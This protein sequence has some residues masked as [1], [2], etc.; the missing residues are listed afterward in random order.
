LFQVE[1]GFL[2]I[3]WVFEVIDKFIMISKV[4]FGQNNSINEFLGQKTLSIIF[5]LS[6]WL[7]SG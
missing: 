7:E 1:F 4:F 3:F 2:G 6:Q 5:Q